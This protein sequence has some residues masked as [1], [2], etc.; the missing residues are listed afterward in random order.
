M[1]RPENATIGALDDVLA[2]LSAIRESV[3]ILAT[4]GRGRLNR[5]DL[6]ELER[7][8]DAAERIQLYNQTIRAPLSAAYS[9]KG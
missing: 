5:D 7:I 6:N 3:A 1:A 4:R 8:L 9:H 2:A